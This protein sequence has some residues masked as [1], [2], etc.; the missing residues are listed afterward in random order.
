M[1]NKATAKRGDL[2]PRA[3]SPDSVTALGSTPKPSK[4]QTVAPSHQGPAST[5]SMLLRPPP[6]SQTVPQECGLQGPKPPLQVHPDTTV[7]TVVASAFGPWSLEASAC[8]SGSESAPW[9]PHLQHQ[10]SAEAAGGQGC[11]YPWPRWAT[12]WQQ[13]W[14]QLVTVML[15][16]PTCLIWFL[17]CREPALCK[18]V[19]TPLGRRLCAGMHGAAPPPCILEKR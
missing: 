1:K 15:P 12:G 14:H 10:L 2:V 17:A 18:A 19:R 11:P 5:H 3:Q 7:D 6:S 4:D 9:G 16:I 13:V 8:C